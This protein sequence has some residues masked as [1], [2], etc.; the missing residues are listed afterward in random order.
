VKVTTKLDI[1][2]REVYFKEM[3]SGV[4]NVFP[5]YN[6]ALNSY[7][8]ASSTASSTATVDAALAKELPSSLEA[9]K[10]SAAQDND[11]VT[12]TAAFAKAH[13]LK[14]I[15]DL[16]SI[17]STMT[18]GAATEFRTREAGLV[19][20]K[21]VYGLTFKG[22]KPLDESGPL[23]IAALKAGTIQAGDIY[24]T[25]PSVTK[26]HFVSLLDPKHLFSVQNV[27]PIINK[28]LAG[29]STIVSTLDAVSAALTTHDLVELVGGVVN[30]HVDAGTVAKQ[31]VTQAKLG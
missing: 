20:L 12:V 14:S 3:E 19:G 26:D 10:P 24:T 27:I 6:G 17:S 29:N 8:N 11:S 22:F 4:I 13:H 18:I 15:A 21:K 16:K 2:A 5:E 28:K 9:L 7:L 31:F 23:T 1:G 25:D 30:D